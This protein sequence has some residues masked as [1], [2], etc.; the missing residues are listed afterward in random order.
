MSSAGVTVTCT[1]A[2]ARLEFYR[3][4]NIHMSGVT[5][6]GCRNGAAVQII[7]A[8]NTAI[9]GSLFI[10]NSAGIQMAQ[11]TRATV[12][13]S[14]FTQ[15]NGNVS[16]EASNSAVTFDITTTAIGPGTVEGVKSIYPTQIFQ[17]KTLA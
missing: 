13:R 17:S 2:T 4:E 1:S 10:R 15:N 14:N 3:V 8:T 16:F 12:M 5:F 9:I 7:T 6:Q 11:V